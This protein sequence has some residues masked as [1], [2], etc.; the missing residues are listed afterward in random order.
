[1]VGEKILP[2]ERPSYIDQDIWERLALA[3]RQ[4]AGG[5]FQEITKTY[6]HRCL[7]KGVMYSEIIAIHG[8]DEL[9]QV[10]GPGMM[11]VVADAGNGLCALPL[12]ELY[13]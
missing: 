12:D 7:G 3:D 2:A 13:I 6:L 10:V 1:M 8:K 11:E 5:I 9:E 4:I